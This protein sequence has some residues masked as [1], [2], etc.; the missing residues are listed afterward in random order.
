M[1]TELISHR[2]S[3]IKLSN[4]IFNSGQHCVEVHATA[5][6]CVCV[7]VC[8]LPAMSHQVAV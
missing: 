3:F 1:K 7:C 4:F 8:V 6:L 2:L 5:C